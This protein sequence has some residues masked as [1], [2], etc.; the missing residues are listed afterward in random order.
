M[1]KIIENPIKMDDLGEFSPYFWETPKKTSSA[2]GHVSGF[3][4]RGRYVDLPASHG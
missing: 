1:V 4:S 2:P 3:D